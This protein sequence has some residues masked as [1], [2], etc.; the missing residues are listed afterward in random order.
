MPRYWMPSTKKDLVGWLS[1][2]F[3]RNNQQPPPLTRMKQNQLYAIYY[4]I[5]DRIYYA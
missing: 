5:R 4:S 1:S 3:A 2:Y